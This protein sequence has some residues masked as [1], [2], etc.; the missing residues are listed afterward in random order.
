MK[1]R[2]LLQRAGGVAV[3]AAV[4]SAFPEGSR[5]P[6]MSPHVHRWLVDHGVDLRH[7][8][9]VD[10]AIPV[11]GPGVIT[12]HRYAADE[13]GRQYFDPE[14]GDVARAEPEAILLVAL[15][16]N[17]VALKPEGVHRG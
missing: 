13:R 16:D 5:I 4:V 6:A 8:Y 7:V 17:L 11:D 10:I 1:R 9:H 2:E 14:T 15:P 12:V 3:A